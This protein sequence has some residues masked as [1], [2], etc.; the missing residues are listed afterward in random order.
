MNAPDSTRLLERLRQRHPRYDPKVYKF[1]L[2]SVRSV[3]N[4][5]AHRRH[6]SGRELV[7][8]ACALAISRYG[9]LARMVFDHWGVGSSEDLGEIVFALVDAGVL[10][11]RAEDRIEDF[12]AAVD[13]EL[14]FE[15]EYPWAVEV[16][17]SCEY[18]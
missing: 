2:D 9:P 5:L 14:V 1:V 10:V 7:D 12:R 18:Q 8:G 16:D 6:I 13:F 11:K 17:A 15:R 4:S 3:R